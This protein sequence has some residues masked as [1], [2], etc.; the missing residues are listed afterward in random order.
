LEYVQK[1]G[2]A[3]LIKELFSLAAGCTVLSGP[4]VASS[5]VETGC[6]V[7]SGPLVASSVVAAGCTELR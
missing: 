2:G 5:V 4:L 1:Q 7:L 6:T 3:F